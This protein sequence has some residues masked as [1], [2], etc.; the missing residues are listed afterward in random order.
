MKNGFVSKVKSVLETAIDHSLTESQ[1]WLWVCSL[2]LSNS[3]RNF[4]VDIL[5]TSNLLT[6]DRQLS[7]YKYLWPTR[8]QLVEMMS[9]NR[10]SILTHVDL[11]LAQNV[12]IWT[13]FYIFNYICHIFMFYIFEKIKIKFHDDMETLFP[14][15]LNNWPLFTWEITF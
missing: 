11:I 1:N 6:L 5:T 13:K 10:A 3:F 14:I 4:D 15:N 2:P 7:S 9:L 12:Y 8:N